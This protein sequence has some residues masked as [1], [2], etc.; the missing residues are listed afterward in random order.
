PGAVH[1]LVRAERRRVARS[2]FRDC[3]VDDLLVIA[4]RV[5]D[6]VDAERRAAPAAGERGRLPTGRRGGRREQQH[7]DYERRTALL[8]WKNRR[9]NRSVSSEMPM[10]L[11]VA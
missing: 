1:D 4:S 8:R 5:V 7:C 2:G 3:V 10:I 9:R 6:G 11:L